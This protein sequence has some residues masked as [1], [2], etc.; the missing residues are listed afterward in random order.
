[1]LLV[2]GA[3]D[4]LVPPDESRQLFERAGSPRR[5]EVLPGVGHFD[6]V[7]PGSHGFKDVTQRIARFLQD[8]M[9]AA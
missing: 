6:W 9:P 4:R 8:V 1:M 7:M 3:A 2:H 5:M